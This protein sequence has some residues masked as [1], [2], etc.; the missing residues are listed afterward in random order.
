MIRLPLG[1]LLAASLFGPWSGCDRDPVSPPAVPPPER[2]PSER[3]VP[4]ELPSGDG[5]LLLTTSRTLG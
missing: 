5:V 1:G 4:A 2:A 3:S